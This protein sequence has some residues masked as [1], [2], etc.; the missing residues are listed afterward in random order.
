MVGK[1]VL[2]LNKSYFSVNTKIKAKAFFPKINCFFFKNK[3]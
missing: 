2:I 3:N 1:N